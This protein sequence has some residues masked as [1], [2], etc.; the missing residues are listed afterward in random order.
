MEAIGNYYVL[1]HLT[2]MTGLTERTLRS[3]IANGVLEGE[4]IGGMWHFSP[5]QVDRFLRHPSVRPG[6]LAKQNALIY[7]FLADTHK[8]SCEACVVLDVPDSDRKSLAEFFCYR[9]SNGNC[10]KVHFAYD[11][12]GSVPRVILKGDMATVLRLV[13]EYSRE[14]HATQLQS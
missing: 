11:G 12:A 3:Y 9:I 8:T 7:D 10:Q 5:E 1:G 6:I 4:K 13:N 14:L 2:L